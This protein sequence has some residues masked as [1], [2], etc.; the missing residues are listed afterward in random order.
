MENEDLARDTTLESVVLDKMSADLAY[1]GVTKKEHFSDSGT[2]TW[3][4]KEKP[5]LT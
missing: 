3:E 1:H 4:P 5:N 2:W